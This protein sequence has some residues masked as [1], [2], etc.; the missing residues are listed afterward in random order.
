M[1]ILE[2]NGFYPYTRD[3]YIIK[4][5]IYIKRVIRDIFFML[6][7]QIC[8]IRRFVSGFLYETDTTFSTN[9]RRL[10][11]SVMVGIDNTGHT[12]PMAFMFITTKLAKS[13]KFA[14]ECLINLCFY[15]CLQPSLICSDFSKGLGA[16]VAAQGA[17]DLVKDIEDNDGFIDIDDVADDS[18]AEY[19]SEFLEGTI[20]VDVAIRTKGERTRLQLCEQHAIEAIKRRLIYSGRYSKETRLVLIDL[21]N[22]WIKA[23]DLEALETARTT[24]LSRL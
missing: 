16:A 17:K 9:T 10:P 19:S 3:E 20:I 23:S 12:F 8:F 11:L 22:R 6:D 2:L 7:K 13:F 18:E 1:T 24:L 14:G 4:G 5:G 21:I 15:D